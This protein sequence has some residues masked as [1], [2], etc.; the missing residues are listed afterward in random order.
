MQA[1]REILGEDD[2]E[3]VQNFQSADQLLREVNSLQEHSGRNTAIR[4]LKS[5]RP[6]LVHLQ[7]FATFL[8][9]AV[10]ADSVSLA[11]LWGVFYLLIQV[12]YKPFL[13]TKDES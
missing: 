10:D 3:F 2:F 12:G 6:Q 13:M 8:A 1:T 4:L 9:L 11:C 7:T 5:L